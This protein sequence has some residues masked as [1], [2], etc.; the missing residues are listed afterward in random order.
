MFQ[1]NTWNN[2]GGGGRG[3]PQKE[4]EIK[5]EEKRDSIQVPLVIWEPRKEMKGKVD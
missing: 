1:F 2:E 3:G 4:A 5:E